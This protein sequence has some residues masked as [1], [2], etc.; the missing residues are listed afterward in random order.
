M[1]KALNGAPEYTTKGICARI[2]AAFPTL[3]LDGK[4]PT[5]PPPPPKEDSTI[6][7]ALGALNR[8]HG[9]IEKMQEQMDRLIT[10]IENGSKDK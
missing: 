10:I 5:A 3:D 8:T 1:S 2:R 9:I 6:D 4:L 7:N